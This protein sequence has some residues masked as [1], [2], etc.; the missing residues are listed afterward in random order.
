[1][2]IMS[3]R[4]AATLLFSVVAMFAVLASVH[5]PEPPAP[6]PGDRGDVATYEAIVSRLR[7]GEPYYT[8]VG[9]ELRS[10]HYRTRE[11]FNWR[12]PLLWSSLAAVPGALGRGLLIGLGAAL[13]VATVL[14]AAHAPLWVAGSIVMQTGAMIPALLADV[15]VLGEIWAGILIGLSVCLYSQKRPYLGVS[16][17]LLALFVREL[18]APFCVVCT[19]EALYRRRW[20]EVSAWAAGACLYAFYYGR[21][22]V[23]VWAHSLP[24]DAAHQSSWLELDGLVSLL[25]KAEWHAYLAS[26]PHW[27]TPLAVTLVMAGIASAWA[28]LHAR[29]AS[30]AYVAFFLVAGKPFDGYWGLVAW[31]S[32]ALACG[33]GVQAFVDAAN[34]LVAP[35]HHGAHES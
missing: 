5:V 30:G 34:T 18:A 3:R 22:L 31:P 7:A 25:T 35:H 28:P 19:L 24:T 32:W 12:T 16:V 14:L 2:R 26:G 17:A 11:V 1:M 29:L 21:H 4:R 33:F 27:V 8:V 6:A 9:S 23:Q 13:L 20:K 10:R 15:T